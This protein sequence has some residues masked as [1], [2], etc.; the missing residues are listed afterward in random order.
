MEKTGWVHALFFSL[1]G[2]GLYCFSLFPYEGVLSFSSRGVPGAGRAMTGPRRPN[3]RCGLC[4]QIT[5][6][7]GIL[8]SP[9]MGPY[10][11]PST[12]RLIFI[13][14]ICALWAPE[15]Y[16]DEN[17]GTLRNVLQAYRRGRHMR[18]SSCGS[19]GATVGCQVSSCSKVF[20]F[21]CL[22]RGRCTFVQTSYAAWCSRHASIVGD[23]ADK[24]NLSVQPSALDD[25]EK[26]EDGTDNDEEGEEGEDDEEGEERVE[27]EEDDEGED[28]ADAMDDHKSAGEAAE[29]R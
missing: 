24:G 17:G 13:H 22:Q 14:E 4:P 5:R 21:L 12:T 7:G 29:D 11:L 27:G 19:L 15:V 16:C 8:P 2:I 26:E 25:V 6:T 9:L 28:L 23:H 20:H 3:T 10:R 1:R 18:C